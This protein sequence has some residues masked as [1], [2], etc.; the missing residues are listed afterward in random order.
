[1]ALQVLWPPSEPH[2]LEFVGLLS[3]IDLTFAQIVIY[4]K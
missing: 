2:D 4:V 1:M 3:A